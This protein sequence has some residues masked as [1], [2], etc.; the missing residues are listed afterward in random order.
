MELRETRTYGVIKCPCGHEI[1]KGEVAYVPVL[2]VDGEYRFLRALCE[3]CKKDPDGSIR[4][5]PVA[6]K[7]GDARMYGN[8]VD[9]DSYGESS[10]HDEAIGKPAQPKMVSK[11]TEETVVFCPHCNDEEPE[12]HI[13]GDYFDE[14]EAFYC[15][16]KKPVADRHT[17]K[18]CIVKENGGV[19]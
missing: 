18:P 16:P 9:K 10:E 7:G 3:K 19:F 5:D 11:V 4:P 8:F 12:C 6:R 13:C 2:H 1:T 14:G 17:C 15:N